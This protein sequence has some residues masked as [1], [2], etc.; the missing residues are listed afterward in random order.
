MWMANGLARGKRHSSLL[1]FVKN[2][3]QFDALDL[4]NVYLV[5]LVMGFGFLYVVEAGVG[6]RL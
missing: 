5:L 6:G 1:L 3:C 4:L 2:H